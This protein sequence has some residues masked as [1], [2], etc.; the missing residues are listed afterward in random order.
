MPEDT[1]IFDDLVP[2]VQRTLQDCEGNYWTVDELRDYLNEGQLEFA[3]QTGELRA[4]FPIVSKENQEV[5]D[6]PNDLLDVLRVENKEGLIVDP[7]DSRTLASMFG[8]SY[9]QTE[10]PNPS[11]YYMDLDG[12]RRLRFYPKPSPSIEAAPTEVLPINIHTVVYLENDSLKRMRVQDGLL[13]VL[14]E[15]VLRRYNIDGLEPVL[16]DSWT[17][18]V[19]GATDF[20]VI[21]FRHNTGSLGGAIYI[22]NGSVDLYRADGFGQ[23]ASIYGSSSNTFIRNLSPC[24]P[25]R[26]WWEGASNDIMRTA[27]TSFAET[28][29]LSGGGFDQWAYEDKGGEDMHLATG[30]N[31]LYRLPSSGATQITTNDTYGAVWV[32]D[33][34]Y[35]NVLVL[36]VESLYAVDT[37]ND[38]LG[39]QITATTGLTGGTN[40][41][42]AGDKDYVWFGPADSPVIFTSRY[43]IANDTVVEGINSPDDYPSNSV[44]RYNRSA[45]HRD[46]LYH[47][48]ETVGVPPFSYAILSS[49]PEVGVVAYWDGVEFDQEEGC[50]ADLIG[51]DDLYTFADDRGCFAAIYEA[52]EQAKVWYVRCP[53]A[54]LIE[55][56][57][58]RAI[59]D[60]AL[61]RAFEK[62]GDEASLLKSQRHLAKFIAR[63]NRESARR[64]KG[65][66][67]HHTGNRTYFF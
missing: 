8:S 53:R 19:T 57:E 33:V 31:G 16:V 48:T 7:I 15:T 22:A 4:E 14:S 67:Q 38:A 44:P 32:D 47:F 23:T 12:P 21:P 2:R 42:L 9:R 39:T 64:L 37:A 24:T 63:R 18:G 62:A 65:W 41:W 40:T 49:N 36:G 13:W 11:Y 10:G 34:L 5:Y 59:I 56:V 1:I 50:L 60:Y 54:D 20:S 43:D 6:L 3:R 25:F 61:F 28:T 17:H 51:E 29:I 46:T 52:E 66:N 27:H 45:A 58:W 26:I 35:A 30:S 55:I